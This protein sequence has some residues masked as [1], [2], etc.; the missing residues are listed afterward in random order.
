MPRTRRAIQGHYASCGTLGISVATSAKAGIDFD[1]REGRWREM[2]EDGA[3]ISIST[4]PTIH[5][6]SAER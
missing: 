1:A 3:G 2:N 4:T 6:T 5:A